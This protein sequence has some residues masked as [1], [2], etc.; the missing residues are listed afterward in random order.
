MPLSPLP[1]RRPVDVGCCSHDFNSQE[2]DPRLQRA[3]RGL[4]FVGA[5]FVIIQFGV[6]GSVY[7]FLKEPPDAVRLGSWWVGIVLLIAS[8]SGLIGRTKGHLMAVAVLSTIGIPIAIGGAA[9]DG[10]AFAAFT[11]SPFGCAQLM[12]VG[13]GALPSTSLPGV[14]AAAAFAAALSHTADNGNGERSSIRVS[15]GSS[16]SSSSGDPRSVTFGS[17]GSS[18]QR[19]VA[20]QCLFLAS[21]QVRFAVINAYPPNKILLPACFLL[22]IHSDNAPSVS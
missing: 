4:S 12:A 5:L 21:T 20:Q 16:S 9:A 2:I 13:A 6:G 15:A 10:A 14:T 19:L 22:L 11:G 8:L 17:T 18:V 3:T 7:Q 1:L